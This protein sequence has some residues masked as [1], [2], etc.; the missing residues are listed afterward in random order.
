[1]CRKLSC[2]AREFAASFADLGTILPLTIGLIVCNGISAGPALVLMGVT[3]I[4]TGMYYR[5]PVPVQP[6]KALAAIAIAAGVSAGEIRAAA[7]WMAGIMLVLGAARLADRLN[8]VFP[9]VLIQ[10]LQLSLGVVMLRA[11][12]K[13]IL[14][15]PDS[16]AAIISRGHAVTQP[17]AASGLI[18]SGAEFQAALILLVIPQLPLTIGNAVLA[19][20]DCALRYFGPSGERVTPGRLA[21]TIGL[22]NMAAALVGGIPVCHGAG[23]MTAYYR[24]GSRSGFSGI[25]IGSLLLIVGIAQG[26]SAAAA[27][28]IMP[29]SMLGL[30]LAYVGLR[31]AMLAKEAFRSPVTAAIVLST[32]AASWL[33]GNLAIALGVGL[34]AK[35]LL[36]DAVPLVRRRGRVSAG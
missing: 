18:P 21:T 20:R 19:T 26:D 30:L 17:A 27:L 2:R 15:Y 12:W 36:Q 4:L 31:H 24:L 25:I 22:A 13:F 33:F 14:S 35:L 3:F 9:R 23:G 7:Y 11:G 1:M 5:L 16:L 6:L 29:A 10:A 28:S 34:A 8:D 32:A